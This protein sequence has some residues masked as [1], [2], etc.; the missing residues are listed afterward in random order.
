[1][2]VR[3]VHSYKQKFLRIFLGSERSRNTNDIKPSNLGTKLPYREMGKKMF[4]DL[5]SRT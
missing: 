5:F 4:K 1:M 2:D 3:Y